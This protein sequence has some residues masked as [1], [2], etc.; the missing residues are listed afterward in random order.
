MME[1]IFWE[2]DFGTT[3]TRLVVEASPIS[4]EGLMFIITKVD[5]EDDEEDFDEEVDFSDLHQAGAGGMLSELLKITDFM[6]RNFKKYGGEETAPVQSDL[7]FSFET[8]TDAADLCER[9]KKTFFG[10]S[11]LF[12]S[13]G[14]YVLLLKND[15]ECAFFEDNDKDSYMKVLERILSE[16][17]RKMRYT[18]LSESFLLEHAEVVL[19]EDAVSKLAWF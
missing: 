7:L 18:E 3:D 10:K 16:Y 5:T 6:R 1:D 19:R 13:D 8:F 2:Y 4:N 11:V 15:F 17:G 14:R 9:I 12:K